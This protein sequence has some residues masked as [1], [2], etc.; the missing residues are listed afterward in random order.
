MKNSRLENGS[1]LRKIICSVLI[2]ML[3]VISIS[4]GQHRPFITTWQTHDG[5]ITIPTY[6]TGYGYS[7]DY[8]VTWKD[9][10]N[11]VVGTIIN[12]TSH[13]TITDLQSNEVYQIEITG[14]FPGIQLNNSSI[15]TKLLSIEQWGDIQWKSFKNAFYGGINMTYNASDIPNLQNVSSMSHMFTFTPK[16]DGN[17]EDW[18]VSNVTD[19]SLMFYEASSFKGNLSKWDVSNVTNMH[20]MF[21][22]AIAFDGDIEGWNVE[23][24]N[25]MGYM[26]SGAT[27]FNRNLESWDISSVENMQHMLDN[28]GLSLENYDKTLA[29]WADLDKNSGE[30]KIPNDITLGAANLTYCNAFDERT[31]L[32]NTFKWNFNRDNP[33]QGCSPFI[34]TWIATDGEIT[35]PTYTTDYGYTY[36]YEIKWRNT[37]NVDDYGEFLNQ[38]GDS[39][40]TGLS[41]NAP[42]EIAITGDFPGIYFNHIGDKDKIQ[43]IDQWGSIKWFNMNHA[44]AGCSKLKISASDKP[45]LSDVTDMKG[46]FAYAGSVDADLSHWDVSNVQ[47]MSYMFDHAVS[48]KGDI[49]SWVVSSVTDMTFMLAFLPD[50]NTDIS[51]WNVSNVTDMYGMFAESKSFN[52]NISKWEV[53]KVIGMHGMFSGAVSFDQDLGEWDISKVIDMGHMLDNTGLSKHH[54]DH[55]LMGWAQLDSDNNEIK[56]PE[57][58]TLGAAGL[59][60]CRSSHDRS[61]LVGGN[62]NWTINGDRPI[63]EPFITTWKTTSPSESITIPITGNAY[64]VDWGDDSQDTN[65]YNSPA[66]HVFETPGEHRVTILGNFLTIHF[67]HS[68]DKDKLLS[69][70]HWGG[71]QWNTMDHAF[72]GCSKL[73]LKAHDAPN[74]RVVTSCKAMFAYAGS[75]DA[76]LSNWDVS[77]VRD[78]SYM[79]SGATS[80]DQNL[81]SWDISNVIDISNMFDHSGLS[82]INYEETLYGWAILPSTPLKLNLGAAG[83]TYCY[84]EYGHDVLTGSDYGWT[85]NGDLHECK[86]FIIDWQGQSISIPNPYLNATFMHSSISN[87]YW[88]IDTSGATYVPGEFQV[89]WGDGKVENFKNLSNFPYQLTHSYASEGTYTVEIHGDFPWFSLQSGERGK[90]IS[91]R[92]WGDIRWRSMKK[93][94]HDCSNLSGNPSDIPDLRLVKDL[95]AMFLRATSFTADL[96]DWDVSNVDN[97]NYMFFRAKSFNADI[98]AWDVS[99]VRNMKQMLYRAESFDQNL[100]QWDISKVTDMQYMLY[101]SGLSTTNYDSTLVGWARLDPTETKIPSNIKFNAYNLTYCHGEQARS[102]LQNNHGWQIYQDELRCNSTNARAEVIEAAQI[103]DSTSAQLIPFIA[104]PNPADDFFWLRSGNQSPDKVLIYSMDGQLEKSL[105]KDGQRYNVS[106]LSPGVYLVK[107]YQEGKQQNLRL[108]KQ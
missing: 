37:E 86:P 100:G 15:A 27:C 70:D 66:T 75:L 33:A 99:S 22:E 34:T 51:G 101:R 65:I 105:E 19:M 56:I 26:L 29:G 30:T 104:Y 44:F 11:Q 35:I 41:A 59:T 77:N 13:T 90:L 46:M 55:T 72:A 48:F 32:V 60:F 68:G 49:S 69:I 84:G 102:V 61:I 31:I 3:L 97:M 92:Q 88:H 71:L 96:S 63:C 107:I 4:Y 20:G 40:I 50:F 21:G 1:A 17:L 76:N 9:S 98:S 42:Y 67:N 18:V 54:Y 91:I 24:V 87:D 25:D 43:S 64:S 53:S 39:K 83:L 7:Y 85:I 52:Q 103:S 82:R 16:F 23:K 81:G 28:S 108:V 45:D 58:I 6:P 2:L 74:L 93:S 78:M 8:S 57:N 89:D 5:S 62:Y 36:Q 14:E 73:T 79:F 106:S 12:Q 94:F 47:D 95:S 38:T 10:N 80:F